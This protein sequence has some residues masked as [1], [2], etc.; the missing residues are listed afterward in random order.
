[1]P[2]RPDPSILFADYPTRRLAPETRLMLPP[3]ED[4]AAVL[5]RLRACAALPGAAPRRDLLPAMDAIEAALQALQNGPATAARLSAELQPLR[6]WRMNRSLAW[7]L[8]LDLLRLAD[9]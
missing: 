7:L 4:A 5:A 2:H 1:V 8:K 3:G 9:G 6:A